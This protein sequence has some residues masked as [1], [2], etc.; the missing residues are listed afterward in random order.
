MQ[1]QI[2]NI[3]NSNAT[4]T[5]KIMLLLELGLSRTQIADLQS[6]GKYGAIQNVFAKWQAGRN[7][8]VPTRL[9]FSPAAF[10][11]RFGIE[12]EAYDI[13]RDM[14]AQALRS[15]GI[16]CY[17]EGY[18]HD[19]RGHWK[20]VTDGSLSGNDTF[21]LVS[22]ILEGENGLAQVRTVSEVLTRLG[23]RINRTCGLHVHFDAAGMDLMNWKRLLTNY[24]A[25]E[26]TIDSMMPMSRRGD[27]NTYCRSMK[28]ASLQTKIDAARTLDQLRNIFSNRYS[29]VNTQAF[30][31][32]KTIEFRQHS[33]TFESQKIE[34]W[35]VFLHNLVDY[36]K[37]HIIENDSFES[38]KKFNSI[39]TVNFYHSR[40]QDLNS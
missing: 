33:G 7:G 13:S 32:H 3:L 39:E 10:N 5:A 30:A 28:I 8:N 16:N 22:P 25:L 18:N 40:I 36:S 14:V 31:R 2:Q 21:E 35:V 27:G 29:K 11:K 4:K 20:V 12:I 38:L 34:N 26:G 37:A 9:V 19:T 1:V 6:L 24:A 15:A 17:T 23:V